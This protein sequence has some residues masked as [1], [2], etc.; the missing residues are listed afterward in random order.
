MKVD[1]RKLQQIQNEELGVSPE[2]VAK[3]A[4][5][6]MSTL[7][8]VYGNKRVSANSVSRVRKAVE[9]LQRTAKPTG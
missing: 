4:C 6:S 2:T 8:K 9:A 3:E 7:Y 1:G 5:V